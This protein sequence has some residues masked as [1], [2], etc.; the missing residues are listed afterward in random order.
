[1][2]SKNI[3][4]TRLFEQL[5]PVPGLPREFI[6]GKINYPHHKELIGLRKV[7]DSIQKDDTPIPATEDREGFYADRHIEYWLSGYRES[8][9]MFEFLQRLDTKPDRIRFLD[10]GGGAGRVCRHV[11]QL[12]NVEVWLCDI[13]A[14]WIDWVTRYFTRPVS[15]FRNS[16]FPALPFESSYFDLISA[17]SV[18]THFDEEEVSWLLELRRIVKPGGVLWLTISDERTWERLRKPQYDWLKRSLATPRHI[19]RLDEL[20]SSEM[21]ERLVLKKSDSPAYNCNTFLS[22]AYIKKRWAPFFDSV[23]FV[24]DACCNGQTAVVLRRG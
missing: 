18:F 10:F 9:L 21:P 4:L 24:S 2:T 16:P 23:D 1:M 7:Q 8:N 11:N 19:K 22:Q 17:F 13:N 14:T 15:A 5:H 3:R 6:E 20:L 12:P